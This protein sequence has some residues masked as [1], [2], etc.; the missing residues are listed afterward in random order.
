M[1][2]RTVADFSADQVRTW[3]ASREPAGD[4]AQLTAKGNGVLHALTEA[5]LVQLHD[6]AAVL[7][8]LVRL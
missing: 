1:T 3:R 8:Q 6:L 4:M 2:S 7:D 5:H